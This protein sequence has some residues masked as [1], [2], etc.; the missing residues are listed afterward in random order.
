MC[1]VRSIAPFFLVVDVA[2]AYL[3]FITIGYTVLFGVNN[4]IWVSPP[5][6]CKAWD[7]WDVGSVVMTSG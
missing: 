3:S 5:P 7:I 4:G 1:R 2:R 6:F